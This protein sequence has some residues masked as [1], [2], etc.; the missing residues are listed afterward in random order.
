MSNSPNFCFLFNLLC[1]LHPYIVHLSVFLPFPVF[2]SAL[3]GSLGRKM[4]SQLDW[5]NS[6]WKSILI[7]DFG[8][9]SY[10]RRGGRGYMC[11]VKMLIPNGSLNL[12]AS[13]MLLYWSNDED[14]LQNVISC[15][16]LY[17]LFKNETSL[18]AKE[19][20]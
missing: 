1:V 17:C 3:Q 16:L 19:T 15:C 13:C 6:E 8:V 7:S 20:I 11:G 14:I 2:I 4:N 10:M 5:E 9:C 18:R 12:I